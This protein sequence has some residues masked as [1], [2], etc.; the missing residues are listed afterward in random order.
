MPQELAPF[1]L[2]LRKNRA[3]TTFG[4]K[5]FYLTGLNQ[6]LPDAQTIERKKADAQNQATLYIRT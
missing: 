2:T 6:E 5:L 3:S 4:F 1:L